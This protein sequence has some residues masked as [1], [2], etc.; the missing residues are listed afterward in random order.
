MVRFFIVLLRKKWML[1]KAPNS[2]IAAS[3]SVEEKKGGA[4][5][6]LPHESLLFLP[7]APIL[8]RASAHGLPRQILP[9]ISLPSTI[10]LFNRTLLAT[11]FAIGMDLAILDGWFLRVLRREIRKIEPI[12]NL[13]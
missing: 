12:A 3:C 8:W 6:F 10:S 11:P 13:N 9:G 7:S 5:N 2:L 1:K 4:T